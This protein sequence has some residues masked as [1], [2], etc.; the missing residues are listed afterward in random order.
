M[1]PHKGS[2]GPAREKMPP[3]PLRDALQ[4]L[5]FHLLFHEDGMKVSSMLSSMREELGAS[6]RLA[7]A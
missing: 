5:H 7:L 4:M 3:S 6:P 1:E 2:A